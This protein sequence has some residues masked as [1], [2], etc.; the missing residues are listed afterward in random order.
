MRPFLPL[1]TLPLPIRCD[2]HGGS[3]RSVCEHRLPGESQT[4][5]TTRNQF[6]PLGGQPHSLPTEERTRLCSFVADVSDKHPFDTY[7]LLRGH[8]PC[9][10]PYPQVCSLVGSPF[11]PVAPPEQVGPPKR[12]VWCPRCSLPTWVTSHRQPGAAAPSRPVPSRLGCD[13]P[14]GRS[15]LGSLRCLELC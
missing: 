12:P 13:P 11:T 15:S 5:V 4:T 2:Y 10:T 9:Q 6:S 7:V 3:S 8:P 14:W 1:V